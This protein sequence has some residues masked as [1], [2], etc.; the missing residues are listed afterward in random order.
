MNR[1]IID[2]I[3]VFVMLFVSTLVP[4]IAGWSIGK[5]VVMAVCTSI[6]SIIY[7]LFISPV[8]SSGEKYTQDVDADS[9]KDENI[10]D[11]SYE[12]IA[13]ERQNKEDTDKINEIREL[14]DSQEKSV[15]NIKEN[16]SVVN[17]SN[18]ALASSFEKLDNVCSK[19]NDD[20]VKLAEA[21]CKTIYLTSVGSENMESMD[22]SIKK[23]GDANAQLDKS[24]KA[25]NN[26]TK[27]AIDIIHLI[28]SIAAQ[29]NLLA[30][31]AAIEAARAGDAGK[32]FSVV[33]SEIRKLADDVKNAVDSVD[34][35]INDITASIKMITEN[36]Q[37]SGNLISESITNVTAAEETFKSIVSEVAE[38][39]AN[40]DIVSN[41]NEECQSLLS[42]VSKMNLQHSDEITVVTDELKSIISASKAI[43]EAL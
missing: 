40:A 28:G 21:I 35:I 34:S 15:H 12:E 22:S 7:F 8:L 14:T 20:S 4:N 6:L 30:L 32:G 10:T 16:L 38:I 13:A 31:N 37:E 5:A 11:N 39:D 17:S 33:A 19:A 1:R 2:I 41:L 27:E 23:I 24:V 9:I 43:K 25:A 26:S 18:D 29:T 3:F 42:T 36:S